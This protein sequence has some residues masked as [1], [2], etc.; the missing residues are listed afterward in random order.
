MFGEKF[1]LSFWKLDVKIGLL[2]TLYFDG[3]W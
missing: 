2:T 1:T 3:S